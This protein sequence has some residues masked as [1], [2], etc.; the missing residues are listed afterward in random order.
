VNRIKSFAEEYKITHTTV[1]PYHPQ[2][3]PVERVN[4]ILKTIIISFIEKDHREWNKHLSEFRFAY[5]I[6]FHS[7]GTSPVF[8]NFG[9]ELP[10]QL[11]SRN[12]EAIEVR[13][14]AEWSERMRKLQLLREWVTESLDRAYQRQSSR[15]NL[16]RRN[17]TFR[18]DDLVL[19]RQHVL[20]LHKMSRPNC[21]INSRSHSGWDV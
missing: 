20:R 3:N 10:V 11:L 12:Q 2:D 1:S 16:R 21:D 18:I 13:N 7:L 8:L 15:Y 14:T 4:R 19:R 9:R 6:A 5:N 17:R